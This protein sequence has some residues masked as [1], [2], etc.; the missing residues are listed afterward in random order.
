M[1]NIKSP[2]PSCHS[3]DVILVAKRSTGV[4][5]EVTRDAHS[6]LET[7]RRCHQMS[8]TGVSVAQQT[9]IMTSKLFLNINHNFELVCLHTVTLPRNIHTV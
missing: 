4:A 8:K 7:Q 2:E 6:G 3:L 1:P 9:G 5:P